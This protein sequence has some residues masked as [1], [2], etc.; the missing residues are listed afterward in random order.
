MQSLLQNLRFSFRVFR[1]N[2][3]FTAIVIITLALG[4]GAVTAIYSVVYATLI[5]DMPYPKPDQIVMVWSQVNGHRS[6]VSAA[7]Y[8]DWKSQSTMFQSLVGWRTGT[9]NRGGLGSSGTT[10]SS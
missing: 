10:P 9:R 6:L 3:G 8:L 7:D 2:A 4:V 5:A 1:K